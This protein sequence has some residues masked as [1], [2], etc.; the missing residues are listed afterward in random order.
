MNLVNNVYVIGAAEIVIPIW[1]PFACWI[2]FKPI[3][4]IAPIDLFSKSL[5]TINSLF[6]FYL[7]LNQNVNELNYIMLFKQKNK[8]LTNRILF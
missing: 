7:K 6:F 4:L 8:N 2:A 1:P 5:F 3:Y